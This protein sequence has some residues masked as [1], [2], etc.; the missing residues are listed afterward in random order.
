MVV[1][2]AFLSEAE[3]FTTGRHYLTKAALRIT[4]SWGGLVKTV[5]RLMVMEPSRRML[6]CDVD[7]LPA[8]A[9]VDSGSGM[10]L[11][12]LDYAEERMWVITNMPPD[13]G[14]ANFDL[15]QV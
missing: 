7:G 8:L 9:D 1:G 11:V 14:S 6:K 4:R 2:H 13:E 5:W 3:V 12:S 15:R 10:D